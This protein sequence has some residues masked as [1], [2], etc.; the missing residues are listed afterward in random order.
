[1][2]ERR[3]IVT[4][5]CLDAMAERC[6]EQWTVSSIKTCVAAALDDGR[7][8]TRKP[9]WIW[10]PAPRSRRPALYVWPPD[11]GRCFVI[12]DRPDGRPLVVLTVLVA[13]PH[14][15][16]AALLG[17]QDLYS[18]PSPPLQHNGAATA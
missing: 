7:C 3:V 9:D 1:M 14:S 16:F 2:G 15:P 10:G 6:C 13:N 11:R 5:H 4:S 8:S 18:T 17:R 12:E